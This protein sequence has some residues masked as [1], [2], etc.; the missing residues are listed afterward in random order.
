M[1]TARAALFVLGLTA[2]SAAAAPVV[3]WR[4]PVDAPPTLAPPSGSAT[5]TLAE[6][7]RLGSF[8]SGVFRDPHDGPLELWA[9]TDR[10]PNAEVMVDGMRRRI[11]AV[12]DFQPRLVKVRVVGDGAARRTDIVEQRPLRY[13]DGR[14]LSGRP[15]VSAGDETP[16]DVRGREL[17]S[18]D[19]GGMDIED[20]VRLPDGSFWVVEEYAPGLAHVSAE[21]EILTRLVPTGRG[22]GS[23]MLPAL[24]ARR[25][26]NR[27]FE[28]LALSGDGR[29]LY[30]ALQSP[31]VH[32]DMETSDASRL[33]RMFTLD[34]A[35]GRPS[36]EQVVV[37]ETAATYGETA[38][39]EVKISSAAWLAEGRLLIGERTDARLRLYLVDLRKATNVLDTAWDD[40]SRLPAL[41]SLT[42]DALAGHGLRAARK[43][44]VL[45]LFQILPQAPE[46]LEGLAV[47]D[48]HTVVVGNDNEFDVAGWDER[49][50]PLAAHRPSELIAVHLD[51]PLPV[52]HR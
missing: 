37:L 16:Y 5:P 39:S 24:L 21:G 7:L 14:P 15:N 29:T 52:R 12:P 27:G 42:P 11:L 47:L 4:A 41:E 35:S 20:L 44:L 1:T 9:V 46:K 13:A 2:S 6:T 25:R 51:K 3:L 26:K 38:Q 8:F 31:L 18:F 22:G 17:L 23:E 43:E 45:D 28:S 50:R 30:A 34:A 19:P 32:P 10:G 36:R 48:A 40:A 49:G 33:V